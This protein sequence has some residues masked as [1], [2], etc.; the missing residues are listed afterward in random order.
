[1]AKKPSVEERLQQLAELQKIDSQL[2]RLRMVRGG[3]PEEVR[4]LEDELDG[5]RLRVE[6]LEA[7]VAEAEQE[8]TN[9]NTL[10]QE[11]RDAISKYERQMDDVKNNREYEA[12]NKEIELAKLEIM[13]AERRIKQQNAIVEEKTA[14]RDEVQERFEERTVDLEAKRQELKEI[15]AETEAEEKLLLAKSDKQAENIDLRLLTAYR[16]IRNNM[17][18]GLAV[19]YP[20]RG[21]CGGCFAIIPPQRL[22]DIRQRKKIIVCENCGRIIADRRYFVADEVSETVLEQG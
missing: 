4:D 14:V 20:D 15:V 16:K 22:H 18:N 9:R 6:S 17:R 21:A 12:L 5:L 8:I 3:L 11:S 7:E 2:D 10:I 13:T 1:M 19:V